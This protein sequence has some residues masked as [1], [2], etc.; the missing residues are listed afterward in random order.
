MNYL[1]ENSSGPAISEVSQINQYITGK[2]I[3]PNFKA[4][5]M[6]A[7][8]KTGVTN[9]NDAS[10]LI[11]TLQNQYPDYRINFDLEDCDNI[12]RIEG[13]NIKT[14]DI[15]EKLQNEGFMCIELE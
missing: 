9:Q 14:R 15:S 12:L 8:F 10:C 3:K 6:I 7:V 11:K 1:L 4:E 5:K 2:N 13:Q